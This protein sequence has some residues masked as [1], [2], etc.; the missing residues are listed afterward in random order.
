MLVETPVRLGAHHH[1]ATFLELREVGSF[2]KTEIVLPVTPV[3]VPF[4]GKGSAIEG[5]VMHADDGAGSGG[6]AMPDLRVTI[7]RKGFPPL[8][9]HLEGHRR[10]DDTGADDDG[11]RLIG[12]ARLPKMTIAAGLS[13]TLLVRPASRRR[14]HHRA[15]A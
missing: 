14:P 11:V 7:Q 3:M 5:G 4:P 12:H 1:A 8:F 6:R 15:T 13:A 10:T 2:G 9:G